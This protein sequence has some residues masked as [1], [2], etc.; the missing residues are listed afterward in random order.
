MTRE[1]CKTNIML[2]YTHFNMN[3]KLKMLPNCNHFSFM[4]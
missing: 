2:C 1:K 3:L 4:T